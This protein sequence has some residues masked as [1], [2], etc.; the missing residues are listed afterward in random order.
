MESLHF[1]SPPRATGCGTG[2]LPKNYM[3]QDALRHGVVKLLTSV[4][5]QT[6]WT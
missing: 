3:S 6:K 1:P 2:T 4:Q 5:E